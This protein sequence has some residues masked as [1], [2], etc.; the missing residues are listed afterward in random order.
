MLRQQDY[1]L[2]NN[3]ML[4]EK[5]IGQR[6]HSLGHVLAVSAEIFQFLPGEEFLVPQLQIQ[7]C[8]SG[9]I[10]IFIILIQP[11]LE[12]FCLSCK[13]RAQHENFLT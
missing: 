10:T 12:L 9:R 1:P 7:C 6:R 11:L 13:P 8:A 3:V 4:L 2:C 5:T